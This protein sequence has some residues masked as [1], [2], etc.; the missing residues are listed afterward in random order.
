MRAAAIVGLGSS[1]NEVAA[2][3]IG[4]G[5]PTLGMPADSAQ[6]D[7][8]LI[9][10]GD[11]TIHRHLPDLVRLKLPVLIVPCGSGNDFARAL[12]L[13]S[14]RDAMS[15]W[16]KFVAGTGSVQEIDLGVI[17]ESLSQSRSE[18]QTGEGAL[19]SASHYFASVAGI[20]LDGEVARRAHSL[21]RWLRGNG[22]Y[23]LCLPPALATFHPLHME[24][25]VPHPEQPDAFVSR[26]NHPIM[27]AA[28]A[29]TSAYGGGM[30]I[31]P[32]ASCI[33]GMLDI[34]VV[35]NIGKMRLLR[36][37]PSVYSGQ[38]I[39]VDGVDYFQSDHVR[40]TTN[41]PTD[42]YAD[43]EY[44]CKTPIEISVESRAL[45]VIV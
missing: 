32:K 37:F 2:F 36:L 11:G 25:F 31:A 8:I 42:V 15:A 14:V 19:H 34:C 18:D 44:V 29:N 28:F 43:G 7:A 23:V 33:D 39:S 30:H 22:G 6:A 3:Q 12:G 24:I 21:P 20:G 4:L 26:L 38:H 5:N 41:K 13:L 9:F 1:L 27:L 16:K 10:G 40:V 35:R 45:R 17:T